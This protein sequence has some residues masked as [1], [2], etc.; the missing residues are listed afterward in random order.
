[1]TMSE[2]TRTYVTLTMP[3]KNELFSIRISESLS[4]RIDEIVE[5]RAKNTPDYEV[6]PA[7]PE[8]HREILKAGVED[9]EKGESDVSRLNRRVDELAEEKEELERQLSNP[10]IGEWVDIT[11]LWVQHLCRRSSD[12]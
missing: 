11:I 6:E 5:N 3:P 1:M 2:N 9:H 12:K 7:D 10:T 8:V 4:E